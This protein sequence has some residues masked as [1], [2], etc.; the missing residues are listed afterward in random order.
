MSETRYWGSYMTDFIKLYPEVDSAKV[1]TYLKQ[2]PEVIDKSVAIFEE[3]IGY[4]QKNPVLV[5]M[6]GDVYRLL[7]KNLGHKYKIAQIK[8]YSSY[9]SK[10]DYREEVLNV[11]NIL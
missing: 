7:D 9:I 8:H 1:K 11:L 6:G 5:A 3:E 2:S 4:L 10:E